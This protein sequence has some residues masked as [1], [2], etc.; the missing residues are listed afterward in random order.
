MKHEYHFNDL[1][2][3]ENISNVF[4][5]L[6]RIEIEIKLNRIG[7]DWNGMDRIGMDWKEIRSAYLTFEKF[8]SS[9]IAGG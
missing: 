2:I 9:N 5:T 1:L 8:S 6:N 7:L 4:N 3:D